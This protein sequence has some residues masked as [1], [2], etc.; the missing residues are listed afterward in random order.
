MKLLS[1]KDIIFILCLCSIF[2]FFIV[3]RLF[4]TDKSPKTIVIEVNNSLYKACSIEKNGLLEIDGKSGK[5]IVEIQGKKVRIK[6]S[7][8]PNQIC[9]KTG[10]IS[11]PGDTIICLPNKIIIKISI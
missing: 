8:C 10:W 1:L 4:F 3:F 11:K 6:K 9:V 7:S 2:L 5:T